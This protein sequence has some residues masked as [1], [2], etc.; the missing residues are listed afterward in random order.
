[1]NWPWRL[2]SHRSICC[3]KSRGLGSDRR[4]KRGGSRSGSGRRDGAG[5]D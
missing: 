3:K 5:Q 4:K 2:V 1:M